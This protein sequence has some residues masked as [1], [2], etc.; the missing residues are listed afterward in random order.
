MNTLSFVGIVGLL[1]SLVHPGGLYEECCRLQGLMLLMLH[2]FEFFCLP[3]L[4]PIGT[5]LG[6]HKQFFCIQMNS[7][8]M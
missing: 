2:C 6:N 3:A 1:V 5:G 8:P 7:V 4:S